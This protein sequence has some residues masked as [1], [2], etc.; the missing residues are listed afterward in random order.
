MTQIIFGKKKKLLKLHFKTKTFS[1]IF[2]DH[3]GHYFG[4]LNY[5]S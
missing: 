3:Q 4:Q 1:F 2:P 5:D